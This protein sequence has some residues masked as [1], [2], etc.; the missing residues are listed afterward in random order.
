MNREYVEFL[1]Q[2]IKAFVK[3][4]L[5]VGTRVRMSAKWTGNKYN[6]HKLGKVVGH[7]KK[8]VGPIVI[9]DGEK[10]RHGYHW[11]FIVPLTK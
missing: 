11:S 5:P 2:E 9:H 7:Q 3:E 10:T 8:L 4:V 1:N 6:H